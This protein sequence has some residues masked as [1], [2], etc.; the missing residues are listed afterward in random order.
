MNIGLL[1]AVTLILGYLGFDAWLD[2]STER[3]RRRLM[4]DD[5][6]R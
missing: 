2:A 3:N 4:G 6:A 5:D 1:A